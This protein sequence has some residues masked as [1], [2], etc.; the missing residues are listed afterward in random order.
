MD[1]SAVELLILDVDGVL[2][3]G[4]LLLSDDGERT[5]LF[6]VQDGYA[7]KSWQ[8]AG[9]RIALLSGRDSGPV[10]HR[11]EELNIEHLRLGQGD[12][13]VGYEELLT[14]LGCADS[15]VAYVGDDLP[16]LGPMSRAAFPIAVANAVPAVK[17]AAWH[18]TQRRGG[19]G[20][21]GE[22]VELLLRKKG[23][24]SRS[25]GQNV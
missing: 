1:P 6:H 16:D 19:E 23:Q 3:S 4:T 11:A 17:K 9:G 7:I 21:V 22:I 14:E 24:W 18:V 12:K 5:K 8:R 15:V 25:L 10:R 2:T 13:L 20:A